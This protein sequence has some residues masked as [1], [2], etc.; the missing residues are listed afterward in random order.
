MHF[1]RGKKKM[2]EQRP[3]AIDI[4]LPEGTEQTQVIEQNAR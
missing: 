4:V 1:E 2:N 3:E